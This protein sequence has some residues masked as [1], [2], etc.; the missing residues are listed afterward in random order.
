MT[1]LK[2]LDAMVRDCLLVD[3]QSRNDD[4]RLTQIV[5]WRFYRQSIVKVGSQHY[6][7]MKDLHGLPREDNIK[8]VRAKIQ[9]VERKFLPTDPLVAK[10][11]GWKRAEWEHYLG[12]N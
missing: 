5:W 1:K 6:V 7:A 11:R 10:K 8:R 9:N 4:I 3:E 2:T 12:Y